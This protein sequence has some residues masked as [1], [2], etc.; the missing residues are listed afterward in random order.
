MNLCYYTEITCPRFLVYK[1]LNW[2]LT[3]VYTDGKTAPRRGRGRPLSCTLCTLKTQQFLQGDSHV[4]DVPPKD[5]T[6]KTRSAL[7]GVKTVSSF[8]AYRDYSSDI[9]PSFFFFFFFYLPVFCAAVASFDSLNAFASHTVI[10]TV[11][12]K[13]LGQPLFQSKVLSNVRCF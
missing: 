7:C 2:G 4:F 3:T 8:A 6:L 13:A 12:G 10:L 11:A 1:C 9:N 5:Y